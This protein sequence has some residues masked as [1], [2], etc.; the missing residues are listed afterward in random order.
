MANHRDGGCDVTD[1]RVRV[2]DHEAHRVTGPRCTSRRPSPGQ[3]EAD[4]GPALRLGREVGPLV[5]NIRPARGSSL[6]ACLPD[7][8]LRRMCRR[9]DHH[10][11]LS[12]V[13]AEGQ[14]ENAGPDLLGA[15]HANLDSD[16]AVDSPVHLAGANARTE[17]VSSVVKR[18]PKV[19][20][21]T[22]IAYDSYLPTA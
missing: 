19:T 15:A 11:Q 22:S 12:R 7:A 10:Q 14:I 2:E 8:P 6:P 9:I 4:Q 21:R 13:W 3:H 18:S 17:R 5:Q 16:T 1:D 20:W